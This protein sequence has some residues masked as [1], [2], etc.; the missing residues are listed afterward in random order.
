MKA[1]R[2]QVL[3]LGDEDERNRQRIVLGDLLAVLAVFRNDIRAVDDNEHLVIIRVDICMGRFL[4]VEGFAQEVGRDVQALAE[5][6]EFLFGGL[7]YVDPATWFGFIDGFERA[8]VRS[9]IGDHDSSLSY[10]QVRL[11]CSSRRVFLQLVL[12]VGK[13]CALLRENVKSIPKC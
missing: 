12:M 9:V 5:P 7:V 13:C 2:E 1:E 6:A 3:L 8:M 11:T 10:A 4:F